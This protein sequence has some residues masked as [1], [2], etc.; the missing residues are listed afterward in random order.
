MGGVFQSISGWE[1]NPPNRSRFRAAHDQNVHFTPFGKENRGQG[2][3]RQARSPHTGTP[4]HCSNFTTGVKP[5]H[6]SG[7]LI[8]S[9][10][11][12]IVISTLPGPPRIV[13]DTLMVGCKSARRY[14]SVWLG[15]VG[16]NRHVTPRQGSR[17]SVRRSRLSPHEGAGV[18]GI[19]GRRL[20]SP[21]PLKGLGAGGYVSVLLCLL[22][23]T[24]VPYEQASLA[25]SL[26]KP[27]AGIRAARLNKICTDRPLGGHVPTSAW[28]VR[29]AGVHWVLVVDRQWRLWS[30]PEASA[31]GSTHRLLDAGGAP[32]S[33]CPGWL[34]RYLVGA[35]C[36]SREDTGI[37][38][39]GML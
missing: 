25:M 20:V 24:P 7:S 14:K 6:E 37:C 28:Q 1:T 17:R 26:G 10:L 29:T 13:E 23:L 3:L 19:T 27:R 31:P 4:L 2:A 18:T 5:P 30:S 22:R 9:P 15:V 34:I 38:H 39:G 35:V 8:R 16:V 21:Y 36:P 12:S 32:H 33:S 11:I